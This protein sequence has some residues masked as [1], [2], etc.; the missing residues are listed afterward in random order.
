MPLAS[1][2]LHTR[3][4]LSQQEMCIISQA[5]SRDFS[6]RLFGS[7]MGSQAKR[8]FTPQELLQISQ[9]ISRDYAPSKVSHQSRL[10]LLAVSPRRLHAYWQVAKRLLTNALQRIEP[11][12]PMMLRIYAQPDAQ[13]QAESQTQAVSQTLNEPDWFD[14]AISADEGQRD[15]IL[16]TTFSTNAPMHYS[17]VLGKTNSDQQ[18]I[19]LTY[20]NPTVAPHPVEPMQRVGLANVMEQFIMFVPNQASSVPKTASSQGKDLTH[21]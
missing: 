13:N 10:V 17:A 15:V 21:D 11:P 7:R 19:P 1:N 16:P 8:G 9:Q 18:F 14:I 6:P 3:I 12:Q 5:I 4:A 20:S 2:Q